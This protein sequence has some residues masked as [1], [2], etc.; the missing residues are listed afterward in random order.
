MSQAIASTAPRAKR[1]VGA[2]EIAARSGID[3]ERVRAML[4][5][6]PHQG[7]S[8]KNTVR[9]RDGEPECRASRLESVLGRSH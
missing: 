2:D 9:W 7:V 1:W 6:Y 4:Q 3:L 5:A 8:H